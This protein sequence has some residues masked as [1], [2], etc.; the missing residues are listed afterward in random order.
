MGKNRARGIIRF[1]KSTLLERLSGNH[2]H[3]VAGFL[4]SATITLAGLSA[5]GQAQQRTINDGTPGQMVRTWPQAGVWQVVLG[6][7]KDRELACAMLTGQED[8]S[9]GE[10][11]I[12]GFRQKG[13]NVWLTVIDKNKR[14]IAGDTIKV[15]IDTAP[16][17]VFKIGE[18]M[19]ESG[20][21]NV[22]AEIPTRTINTLA[23]LL[24]I[25]GAVKFVTDSATYSA[26]L[27]GVVQAMGY[28]ATCV[29][30]ADELNA[31]GHAQK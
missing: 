29:Q 17:E 31:L 5:S 10:L 8:A 19:D 28:L 15:V 27:D 24:R 13:T 18:R 30:E 11:Y 1:S 3:L 2:A 12:W 21:Q 20:M 7:G 22:R 25:G 23:R 26:S 16:I 14:A 4:A 6:V 9:I